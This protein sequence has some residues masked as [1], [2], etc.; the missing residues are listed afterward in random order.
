MTRGYIYE[1]M[2]RSKLS[3]LTVFIMSTYIVT[4]IHF[5]IG[6]DMCFL[7]NLHTLQE[8][9]IIYYEIIHLVMFCDYDSNSSSY[10][11][12]EVI[13]TRFQLF[14]FHS[15]CYLGIKL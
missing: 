11:H 7:F 3:A 5:S 13:S 6:M 10:L 1:N 12:E 14:I 2:D 15:I 8:K 9:N 4:F